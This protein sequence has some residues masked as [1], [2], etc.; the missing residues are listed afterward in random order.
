MVG[1]G[2]VRARLTQPRETL[3]GRAPRSAAGSSFIGTPSWA[4][5]PAPTS[6][7]ARFRE[8]RE[9]PA[10]RPPVRHSRSRSAR[11]A[12]RRDRSPLV[13]EQVGARGRHVVDVLDVHVGQRLG[14]S[15]ELIGDDRPRQTMWPM[16]SVR[17]SAGAWPRRSCS[18]RRSRPASDQ[19][20]GAGR[21]RSATPL[22]S[23]RRGPAGSSSTRRAS[24]DSSGD[25]PRGAIRTHIDTIQPSSTA[26]S[27]AGTGPRARRRPSE[28]SA[29]EVLARGRARTRAV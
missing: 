20:A 25:S 21:R 29:R 6:Y 24:I 1:I 8:R 13:A 7:W 27:T 14:V 9:W 17:L 4:T 26:T 5:R 11:R 3:G 2:D 12:P 28:S 18:R 23:A 22:A 16:S 15:A 19:H 10:R